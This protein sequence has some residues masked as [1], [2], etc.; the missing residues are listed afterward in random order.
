MRASYFLFQ[1][2]LDLAHQYWEKLVC[3]G[4]FV[5]DATC[6]NGQDTLKLAQLAIGHSHTGKIYACDIQ[7]K[8]MELTQ[9]YLKSHLTS[10]QLLHIEFILGCHSQFPASILSG[11]I[12]LIVYNLGYLPG[13]NKAQTTQIKTTLQSIQQAQQLL[14]PGGAIS[15]TCYPGH[16]EGAEE[17]DQILAYAMALSP[18][19]WSCC[20]HR[21]L[22]R[23]KSPSLLLLQKAIEPSTQGI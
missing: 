16:P 22:N 6:G 15:L 18:Q 2:H 4:D 13:G 7:P 1:S 17:E 14:Q 23:R 10:Q 19:E 3:P 12:K 11:T 8:A 21:W 5:I 9:Y 20:H